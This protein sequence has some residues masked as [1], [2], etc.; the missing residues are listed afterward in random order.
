MIADSGPGILFSL[1]AFVMVISVLVFVHEMGHYLVARWVGVKA[2]T[3]SIG[4]GK[5]VTGWTDRR[6][7][8]W[9][10]SAL[11]FGGYVQFAGDMDPSSVKSAEW[12]ALPDAERNQ[13]FQS[14]SLAKRAAIVFAGPAINFLLAILIIA[15]FLGVF[16]QAITPTT[17]AAPVENSAA[18]AM[19][20]KAGDTVRSINGQSVDTFEELAQTVAMNPGAPVKVTVERGDSVI[21]LTGK[22]GTRYEAD[23]FGNRFA[24]GMLGIPWPPQEM[25]DVPIY[26]LPIAA[27]KTTADILGAMITG[28]GQIIT[29]R[30]PIEELGGPM[31]IAQYSGEQLEQGGTNFLY[32]IALLSINLGFINLLP[33]P[34]LDG[35]HLM[36][37]GLEAIR[38]RP[39]S[40]RT[41]EWLFRFGFAVL[42]S[43]MM[44]ATFNDLSSFGL[45]GR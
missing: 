44:F 33:I 19:G 14:K 32:F 41:Q 22:I 36:L 16:G 38:R 6:G 4:F 45:F 30:R 13:T 9:K 18:A 40:A 5:E 28:I 7:T 43:F 3:F 29:G 26:E 12:L 17:I 20:L 31:K 37:Y 39:A 24:I 8:R 11:P 15:G 23:R 25:R 1:L 34:M 2:E 10:L 35:G 27:T 42:I 21:D